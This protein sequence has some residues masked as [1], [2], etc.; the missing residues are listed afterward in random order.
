[1]SERTPSDPTNGADEAAL[2]ISTRVMTRDGARGTV[3][4]PDGV[5]H[6]A[7]TLRLDHPWSENTIDGHLVVSINEVTVLPDEDPD[8]DSDEPTRPS[9]IRL[10]APEDRQ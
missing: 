3:I 7:L 10:P 8:T 1:M 4:G 2:P 5:D 9:I 6:Q